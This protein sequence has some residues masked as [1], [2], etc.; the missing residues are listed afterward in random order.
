MDNIIFVNIQFLSNVIIIQTKVNYIPHV[1]VT[2]MFSLCGLLALK[3][4]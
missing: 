4:V 2:I 1:Y 3:S